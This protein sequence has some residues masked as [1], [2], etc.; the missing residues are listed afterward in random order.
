[1]APEYKQGKIVLS[2]DELLELLAKKGRKVKQSYFAGLDLSDV[3]FAEATIENCNIQGCKFDG[4]NLAGCTLKYCTTQKASFAGAD[5]S[6]AKLT[7][8]FMAVVLD[9]ANL[10][11][12][13]LKGT[14]M[15]GSAKG[16]NFSGVNAEKWEV[17]LDFTGANL[18]GANLVKAQCWGCNFTGADVSDTITTGIKLK[19][20]TL[21]D[22]QFPGPTKKPKATLPDWVSSGGGPIIAIPVEVASTWTGSDGG[23]YARACEQGEGTVVAAGWVETSSLEHGD[24][25]VLV[26][27]GETDTTFLK[28]KKGG[29]FIRGGENEM[30]IREARAAVKKVSPADWQ[31]HAFDLELTKGQLILFDAGEPGSADLGS[32]DLEFGVL[33]A[34]PGKGTFRVDVAGHDTDLGPLV[35]IRLEKLA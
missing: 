22:A 23:D 5:L 28:N 33:V 25:R 14:V 24:R 2:K 12:A 26:M 21:G 11:G 6:G 18:R 16:A 27:D 4:A 1:M 19:G 32:M 7:G 9:S 10:A 20:A 13:Q 35:F 29:V 30:S 8:D 17:E 31:R 34:K 3:D 15:S